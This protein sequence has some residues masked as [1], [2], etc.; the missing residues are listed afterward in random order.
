[1]A[2]RN[3]GA[4]RIAGGGGALHVRRRARCLERRHLREIMRRHVEREGCLRLARRQLDLVL[5]GEVVAGAR[6]ARHA[7]ALVEPGARADYHPAYGHFAHTEYEVGGSLSV[8]GPRIR[9]RTDLAAEIR[10]IQFELHAGNA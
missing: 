6:W 10:A 9:G 1:E 4:G 7:K 3:G 2:L 8:P 5:A